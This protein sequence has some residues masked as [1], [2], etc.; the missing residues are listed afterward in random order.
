VNVPLSL[1][2]Q[3]VD[4]LPEPTELADLLAGLG[5]AVEAVHDQPGIPAGV[6][7]AEI[8][9][10]EPIE[11]S[12]HLTRTVVDDGTTR[13]TVVCG[14]PNARVGVRT[15]LALPGTHLPAI[16][17]T[18]ESRSVMGVESDGMLCSAK[19]LGAYDD[20]R[21]IV[22]YGLDVVPG[23]RLDEA[24]PADVILELELTP[25]RADAFSLLG[26]AR[27]VTA[28]LGQPLHDPSEAAPRGDEGGD[29]GLTVSLAD[30]EGC[31]RLVLQRIDDVHVAP[32]PL[33]LQRHLALLGLRPRNNVVDVTNYVTFALGQ[34][35][36]AYDA[37]VLHEGHLHVRRAHADEAVE[38]LDGETYALHERDL[39]IATDD[40]SGASKAIGLA[41]VMGGLHDSVRDDTTTV[42]LEVAYFDPVTVR[43]TAKRH[44]L[45]TDAHVRFERGVDPEL[46]PRAAAYAASLI[47]DVAG[48]TVHPATTHAGSGLTR[49]SI[50]FRPSRVAFLM[51]FDVPLD[52]QRR[53]LEALGCTVQI[54][55]EDDWTVTPPTWRFDLT[56]EEDLVEEVARLHGYEHI[57]STRPDMAF[58]PPRNDPTHRALRDELAAAGLHET[59]HYVFTGDAELAR[60]RAPEARVRL[61]NPQGI[62]RAC[63]RTALYPGLLNAA[64]T[65]R[66]AP[67]LALFEVGRVFLEPERERLAI[68]QFGAVERSGWRPDVPMDVWRLKGLLSELAERRNVAFAFE[69]ATAE[70]APM[71][72]PGVAARVVWDGKPIGFAG[73]LHPEVAAAYE[74]GEV[75][76]A[77]IDL[78]L[79][80]RRLTVQDVARQPYAERDVAIVAPRDVTYATLAHLAR[81]A[82]GDR[83]DALFAFDV[84]QG[85]P[86]AEEER[87]VA[88]RL[89]WRDAERALRDEEVDE[90]LANVIRAVE[91]AG[92]RIRQ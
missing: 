80:A 32:S 38:L 51:A 36:H 26:V 17:M 28:K 23:A 72:H 43:V 59:I 69:P 40:A 5:L 68:L 34:P 37:R 85:P 44:G 89:R 30:E 7:A 90:D 39:V 18:V 56:I 57:G 87:S 11:G 76:L 6:I 73:R 2:R 86:L 83:L 3:F 81:G 35:S 1:L 4:P 15:A 8:V 55:G 20:A 22:E 92:Y 14:A 62:E 10:A 31:P 50:S 13:R 66:G 78:P 53:Y 70:E 54:D 41:G 27:D 45:H 75:Y 12:D 88:L 64:V 79:A 91:T 42:A 49:P 61:A 82:A 48:G 33:W 24:W 47:A 52:A 16:G 25:N 58:T 9:E 84:Y 46:Q 21:G 71:L 77:E 74:L 67:A 29:D 65:N 60:A 19:E 63:L